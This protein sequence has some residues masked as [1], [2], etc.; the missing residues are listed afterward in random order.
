M[1]SSVRLRILGRKPFPVFLPKCLLVAVSAPL[2]SAQDRR[3]PDVLRPQ[4]P[5][6]IAC[7]DGCAFRWNAEKQINKL[8]QNKKLY[9][10]D[11]SIT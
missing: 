8:Y 5:E 9:A 1:Q 2:R 3:P 10:K 4:T 6:I 7:G 11:F